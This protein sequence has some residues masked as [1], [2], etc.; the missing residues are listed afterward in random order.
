MT[1]NAITDSVRGM[2]HGLSACVLTGNM[3]HINS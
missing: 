2:I 3:A 1:P